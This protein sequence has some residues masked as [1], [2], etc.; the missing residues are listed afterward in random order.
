[1]ADIN[2]LLGQFT[3]MSYSDIQK[4]LALQ[5]LQFVVQ[6]QNSQAQAALL[7]SQQAQVD[8]NQSLVVQYLQAQDAILAQEDYIKYTRDIQNFENEQLDRQYISTINNIFAQQKAADVNL[9]TGD[10]VAA[11]R[12]GT[13][14]SGAAASGIVA[15]EGSSR[16]VVNQIQFETQK[17]TMNSYKDSYNRIFQGQEKALEITLQK[18]FSNWTTEEQIQFSIKQLENSVGNI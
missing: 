4:N 7:A 17:D 9:E 10:K 3:G 13:A 16:D 11:A 5:S 8:A 1:M 2:T 14:L 18:A 12:M 6:Q 15:G